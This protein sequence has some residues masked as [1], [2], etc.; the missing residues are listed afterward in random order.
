MPRSEETPRVIFQIRKER[1]SL[2]AEGE[3]EAER[4]VSHLAD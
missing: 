1:G 3:R 2:P 4:R